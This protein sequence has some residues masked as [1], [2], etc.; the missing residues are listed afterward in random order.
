MRIILLPL[1]PSQLESGGLQGD[2]DEEKRDDFRA[3]EELVLSQWMGEDAFGCWVECNEPWKTEDY[4]ITRLPLLLNIDQN[5]RHCFCCG[6]GQALS[7][8]RDSGQCFHVNS[9]AVTLD[10]F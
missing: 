5:D 4:A 3:A 6:P 2:A 9:R 1:T 10:F 7:T 8:Q